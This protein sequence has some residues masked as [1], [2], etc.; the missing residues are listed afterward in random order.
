MHW[1]DRYVKGCCWQL[2][3]LPWWLVPN[4][5]PV[6]K[7][8]FDNAAITIRRVPV[9]FTL[10]ILR[11]FAFVVDTDLKS[12]PL[13]RFYQLALWTALCFFLWAVNCCLKNSISSGTLK[14]KQNKTK[15]RMQHIQ[16][17][18][19]SLFGANPPPH[20]RRINIQAGMGGGALAAWWG[21]MLHCY[22]NRE[23]ND[24]VHSA[25]IKAAASRPMD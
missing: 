5:R 8:A 19:S 22:L 6:E 4:D 17:S 14:T 10:F 18:F 25:P 11:L 1:V 20:M 24:E 23:D 21:Y 7:G 3:L 13:G 16:Y 12:K 9:P 15:P 2:L